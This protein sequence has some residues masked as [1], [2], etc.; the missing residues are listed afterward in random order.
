MRWRG[1]WT[2]GVAAIHTV[3]AA[4]VFRQPL[5]ELVSRGLVDTVGEDALLNAVAWFV[6]F[7]FVLAV[8]G[9]A[10]DALEARGAAPRG[11]GVGLLA[12]TVLGVALMPASGLWLLLPPALSLV[13]GDRL[14]PA[15]SGPDV[16]A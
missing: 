12:M 9:Q 5:G 8:A 1:R 2:M 10:I 15:L 16:T 13:R 3:F 4:V 14:K 7:G 11:L 6:F